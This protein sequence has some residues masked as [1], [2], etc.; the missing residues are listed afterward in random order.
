M[1]AV[2]SGSV[3]LAIGLLAGAG[4]GVVNVAVL[5]AGVRAATRCGRRRAF[6]LIAVS[7]LFRYVLI[8]AAVYAM[9]KVGSV[10]MA[11]AALTVLLGITLA[12]ALALRRGRAG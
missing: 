8:A 5:R 12:L 3:E 7:Y 6:L 10:G 2:A 11:L 9:L 4:L 1:T